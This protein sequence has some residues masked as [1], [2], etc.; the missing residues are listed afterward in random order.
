MFG[1]RIHTIPFV[2]KETNS[3]FRFNI[4]VKVLQQKY[5]STEHSTVMEKYKL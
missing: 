2:K 4:S 5:V 1:T 3:F